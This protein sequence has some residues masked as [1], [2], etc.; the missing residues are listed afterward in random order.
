MEFHYIIL[1]YMKKVFRKLF[2]LLFI[3]IISILSNQHLYSQ[4]VNNVSLPPYDAIYSLIFKGQKVGRAEISLTYNELD[5]TYRLFQF[6]EA[7][8]LAK[9]F[10]PNIIAEESIFTFTNGNLLPLDFSY[11]DSG[12][13]EDNFS[14]KYSWENEIALL[15]NNLGIEE[16]KLEEGAYDRVSIR[17]KLMM[18]MIDGIEIS[19]YQL[20]SRDGFSLIS[21]KKLNQ[22]EINTELGIFESILYEQNTE[23]SSRKLNYWVSPSDNYLPIK[24]EQVVNGEVRTS[25][26]L[27]SIEWLN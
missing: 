22:S 8:G 25:L 3:V 20:L 24:I 11:E 23:N 6:S 9:L 15:S 18:D 27:E 16:L 26:L 12:D 10:Y 13:N 14:I 21:Y 19:K 1:F 4:S 5:N 17:A 2:G 7:N